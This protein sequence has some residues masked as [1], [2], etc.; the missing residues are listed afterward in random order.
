MRSGQCVDEG[1]QPLRVGAAVQ[2]HQLADHVG[3][4]GR[5]PPR[6]LQLAFGCGVVTAGHGH[7]DQAQCSIDVAGLLAMRLRIEALGLVQP[8][9]ASAASAWSSCSQ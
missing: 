9:G 8:A 5:H 6:N 4:V 1:F 2:L 7:V 3:I